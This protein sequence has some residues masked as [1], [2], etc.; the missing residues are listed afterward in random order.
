MEGTGEGC[1]CFCYLKLPYLSILSQQFCRQLYLVDIWKATCVLIFL[2]VLWWMSQE[3]PVPFRLL[4]VALL[5]RHCPFHHWIQH[6]PEIK[7]TDYLI[8]S[9][10]CK[11]APLYNGLAP[12]TQLSTRNWVCPMSDLPLQATVWLVNQVKGKF[13]MHFQYIPWVWRG[14]RARIA[15][16]LNLQALRSRFYHIRDTGYPTAKIISPKW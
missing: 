7:W 5:G 16:L 11:R 1:G 2:P 14:F 3:T 8:Q 12:D 15:V 9:N 4:V 13:K 6:E 10:L